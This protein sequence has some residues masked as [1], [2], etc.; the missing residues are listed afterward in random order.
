MR[1]PKSQKVPRRCLEASSSPQKLNVGTKFHK[2]CI[3][4]LNFTDLALTSL[5]S[6]W[7]FPSMG[8]CMH[9]LYILNLVLMQ[10]K[11]KRLSDTRA[12]VKNHAQSY[13]YNR[14]K[15]VAIQRRGLEQYCLRQPAFKFTV[16]TSHL[17]GNTPTPILPSNAPV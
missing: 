7:I 6:K 12:Q 11:P 2:I 14:L 13:I 4:L 9:N 15:R 1:E 17:L 3:F 8:L 10:H 5:I 16:S